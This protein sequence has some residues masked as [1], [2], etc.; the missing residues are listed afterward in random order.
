MLPTE[1]S[2][3]P[4]AGQLGDLGGDDFAV[5]AVV[6]EHL[7]HGDLALGIDHEVP[8]VALQPH[9]VRPELLLD[10]LV[11]LGHGLQLQ[12]LLGLQ[13][14]LRVLQDVGPHLV[15]E[16]L[17]DLDVLGRGDGVRID[18][19]GGGLLLAAGRQA[20]RGGQGDDKRDRRAAHMGLWSCEVGSP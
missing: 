2:W 9:L 4:V 3:H 11:F 16:V 10:G 7:D 6:V 19:G 5:A 17:V 12:S 1:C 8:L 14:D 15:A 18:L 20:D 13:Q